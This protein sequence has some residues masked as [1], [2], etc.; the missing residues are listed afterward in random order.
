M[1]ETTALLQSRA[2]GPL[3]EVLAEVLGHETGISSAGFPFLAEPAYAALRDHV[4]QLLGWGVQTWDAVDEIC[5]SLDG[6][7]E[8]QRHHVLQ[9][10]RVVQQV[11][12]TAT[13][14][15]PPA[16]AEPLS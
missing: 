9:S 4:P 10:R 15:A 12:R 2:T 8:G 13:I 7:D 3:A 6:L 1:T 11:L 5:S 14:T 16:T